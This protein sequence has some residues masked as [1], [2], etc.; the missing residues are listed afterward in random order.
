MMLLVKRIFLFTFVALLSHG[1][2]ARVTHAESREK[3]KVVYHINVDD[4]KVLNTAMKTIQNHLGAVGADNLDLR[5][6]LHGNGIALLQLAHSDPTFQG[7]VKSL[8]RQGV[9]FIVCHSTLAAR[10]IDFKKDLY[11]VTEADIVPSGVAEIAH[12]QSQGFSY[13]KP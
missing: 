9:H 11:D 13:V 2:V 12:L 8:K 10:K 5:V 7:K 3:Q 1:V 6:V 4:R